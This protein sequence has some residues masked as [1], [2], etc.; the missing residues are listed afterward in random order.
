M[1]AFGR[2]RTL[3]FV[4]FGASERIGDA[5][6]FFL[7]AGI[8]VLSFVWIWRKVPETKGR[9]LEDM[10]ELFDLPPEKVKGVYPS[11]IDE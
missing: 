4:D 11:H 1:T 2:K 10:E 9:S 8:A 7:F 6:T 3:D 5:T